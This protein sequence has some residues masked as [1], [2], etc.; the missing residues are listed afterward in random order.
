MADEV[1]LTVPIVVTMP[2]EEYNRLLQ[3]EKVSQELAQNNTHLLFFIEQLDLTGYDEA[4]TAL[5]KRG[6]RITRQVN[7]YKIEKI[8]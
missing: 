7:R 6:Y 8:K 4:N 1:K 2:M 3:I 5:S